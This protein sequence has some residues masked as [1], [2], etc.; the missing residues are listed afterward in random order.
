MSLKF[1]AWSILVLGCLLVE[2]A[3]AAAAPGSP[4]AEAPHD[5]VSRLRDPFWPV[6]W[7]PPKL[8]RVQPDAP[9]RDTSGLVRWA[10]AL[11]TL[12][13]IG[14]SRKADGSFLAV[15]KGVGVVEKG[16]TFSVT[17]DDLVYRWKVATITKD[18]IIPEKIGV[19]PK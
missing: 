5:D 6:G 11:A 9:P 7:S 14:L 4:P 16:D 2:G 8:G 1:T 15:L 18:G 3:A 19:F 13:V 12:R 10:D 17:L